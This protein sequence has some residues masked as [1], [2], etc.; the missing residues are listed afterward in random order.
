VDKAVAFEWI[1]EAFL[2]EGQTI[3]FILLNDHFDTSLTQF[4]KTK[5]IPTY[6]LKLGTKKDFPFVWLKLYHLLKKIKPQLVHTHLFE[7]S[8]LGLSAAKLA[9][10]KKRIYTRHHSTYHH[11]YFPHAVKYDRWINALASD[12]VA[13]SS[14]VKHVLI[15]K[16]K[17]AESKIHLIEHG[18]KLEQFE[19]IP[20]DRINRLQAKHGIPKNKTII[21]TI[22]RYIKLKGL[23]YVIE[24]FKE[25]YE[26]YPQT[27]LLLANAGGGDEQA[28][29]NKLQQLPKEAYTE[30]CFEEDLFALYQV[31]DI[32]VHVPINQEIEAFG[33]TYV[34]A[35]AAGVPSVFTLSGIANDFI[36]NEHNALVVKPQNSRQIIQAV[37]RML[38]D[39]TLTT[40]LVENGKK[41]IRR[42]SLKNMIEG[43]IK[44]YF[45]YPNST[46]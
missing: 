31:I 3:H 43:L 42:F 20:E 35:L 8:L 11:E 2:K 27:H 24:A 5:K 40:Q 29:K 18:F 38:Q 28:I 6:Q 44:C 34:E 26:K 10:V 36:E 32:F 23:D 19:N 21:A 39:E 1:V 13:I 4:L 25:V 9:G 37:E 45:P 15:Q 22:S 16:E 7:A 14:N 30:I 41:S 46:E 12:I 17:V 33:Q